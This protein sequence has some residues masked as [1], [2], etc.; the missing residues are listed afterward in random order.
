LEGVGDIAGV[1]VFKPVTSPSRTLRYGPAY[2]CTVEFWD[3]DEDGWRNSPRSATLLGRRLPS[4][5]ATAKLQVGEHAYPTLTQFTKK[6]MWDVDFPV[7]VV[8][9]WVDGADPAWLRRRAEFS[10]EGYHAEA[11]NAARYLSRDE[12]RYSLRS[13]HMYAPWVRTVYLVTDDQTPSWLNTAVP[14]IEVVS[15]KDIFRSSAGLPTFNSHAI[16]SQLH[17]IE[18]LSEHFLYFNDDVMLGNEVTPGDFFLSS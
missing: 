2:G 1:R 5:E 4:L 18:G 9:T 13:L 10:G 7:D 11:A 16:E 6:L 15:H 3:E 14:G 12:L 17:H 8:Y